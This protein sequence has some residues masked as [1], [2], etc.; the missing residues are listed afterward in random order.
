MNI[1]AF[2]TTLDNALRTIAGPAYSVRPVP[3][4][5]LP[6]AEL[7]EAQKQTV[8]RLMRVNH[9]GEVCAQALYAGQALTARDPKV[10]AAMRDT[11]EDLVRMVKH[12]DE[13]A[14]RGWIAGEDG[15]DD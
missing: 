8:A 5:D 13:D 15:W 4:E 14:L 12:A 10:Q 1:D 11:V 3:G 7:D 2:I 6:E 9:V